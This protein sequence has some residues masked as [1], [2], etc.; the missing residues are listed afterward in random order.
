MFFLEIDHREKN[1]HQS[2]IEQEFRLLTDHDRRLTSECQIYSEEYSTN[3]LDKE[4]EYEKN[5]HSNYEHLQ[6]Q[7]KRSSTTL[8]QKRQ[9]TEQIQLNIGQTQEDIE[10]IQTNINNDKKV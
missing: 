8:E 4:F 7:L 9:L 1:I 6:Q 3:E 10:Q 5:L 2:D